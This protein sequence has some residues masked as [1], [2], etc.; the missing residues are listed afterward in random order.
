MET[1][2]VVL[3]RESEGVVDDDDDDDGYIYRIIVE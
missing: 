1:E 2:W 3:Q